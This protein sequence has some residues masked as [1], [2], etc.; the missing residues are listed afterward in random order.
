[1]NFQASERRS[2]AFR[3]TLT[4]DYTPPSTTSLT[5]C[6]CQFSGRH[7]TRSAHQSHP[8][9]SARQRA[10][11]RRR[12]QRKAEP[13]ASGGLHQR[14]R[15][16]PDHAAERLRHPR[17]QARPRRALHESRCEEHW[18]CTAHDWRAGTV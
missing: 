6:C 13:L 5:V 18:N 15:G 2:G 3:L 4:P 16:L 14:A 12:R 10:A 7:C 9:V 1:L 17:P 11:R 8:R